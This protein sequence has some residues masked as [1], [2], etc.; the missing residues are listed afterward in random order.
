MKMKTK[1]SALV[2]A[3]SIFGTGTVAVRAEENK[4]LASVS[5][6]VSIDNGG[7]TL[8]SNDKTP[9]IYIDSS[10]DYAVARAAGDL[11]TDIEKVTGVKPSFTE[12]ET[13]KKYGIYYKNGTMKMRPPEYNAT[14]T[15]IA[16]EYNENG[17]VINTSIS[18]NTDENGEFIFDKTIYVEDN[19][20]IKGF[21]WDSLDSM[22]PLIDK[23]VGLMELDVQ[24]ADADIIIGTVGQSEAIDKLVSDGKIDV[25]DIEGKWECFKIQVV[26]DTLVIAG[27]DRRGTIYGIYDLSEKIG[28][29]P[30]YYWA[31]TPIGQADAL[32]INL[33]NPYT[34]GEPSVKYRGIFMNDEMSFKNRAVE[35]G[36]TDLS[37]TYTHIYELILR[38]KANYMWPAMQEVTPSFHANPVN[39]ENADKYG[40]VMGA[41]HCEMLMRNNVKELKPFE[42]K[43]TSEN[44]E[45]TLYIKDFGGLSGEQ[46]YVYT[47]TNPDTGE[48]VY[49]KE[50][51]HDYW[52]ESL[53]TYGS[54]DNLYN[55]GMRGMHDEAWS[56]VG[57]STVEEKAALQEEIIT[58]QRGLIQEVLGKKAEE[59]PQMFIPYKEMQEVY[60]SGMNIPDDVT[61]MWTDDNYGYIRQLPTDENRSRE[62]GAGIYYHISYHGNPN[63]YLWLCTTPLAQIREE[64]VKAYDNNAKQVWVANVGD[65]KPGERQIEYFLDLA[66]NINTKDTDLQEYTAEK[67]KR[68]YQMTDEQAAEYGRMAVEFDKLSFARKPEIFANNLFNLT[69]YGD[70]GEKYVKKYEELTARCESLY[71]ETNESAKPSLFEMLL[72][73]LRSCYNT[74]KKYIYAD[75]SNSYFAAGRGASVNKYAEESDNSYS[76]IVRD[77]DTYNSMFNKKWNKIMDPFQNYWS[78]RFG[79]MNAIVSKTISTS[80]AECGN[81]T[82]MNWSHENLD[83]SAYSTDTRFVDIYNTGIGS[84]EY[85]ITADKDWV[86]INKTGGTVY[87]DDRVWIGVDKDKAQSGI[88]TATLAVERISDGEVVERDSAVITFN[89]N[90]SVL[91]EKTYAEAD[92]YVSI[93]AEHFSNAVGI[94]DYKWQIEK[95]F[96]RSG[97]SLKAYPNHG[98]CS[99]NPTMDNTA[100]VEYNAYFEN[101]GN[102]D[103]DIYRIPTLNERGSVR[104]AI[105]VDDN[106]PT[107]VTG[108]NKY[109]GASGNDNWSK[110]VMNNNETLTTKLDIT[111]AGEHK[112]RL[113]MIDTGVIIDKIV[114]TTGEKQATYFGAEESYNTTYN[115]EIQILP[116]PNET[117]PDEEQLMSMNLYSQ[118]F[119]ADISSNSTIALAGGTSYN[120]TSG[121]VKMNG[122]TGGTMTVNTGT[123][124][125]QGQSVSVSSD[126]AYGKISGKYMTYK[127]LDSNGTELINSNISAYNASGS[128]HS[129]KVG[130]AEQL[131]GIYPSVIRNANSALSAGYTRYT[132]VINSEH[133]TITLKIINLGTKEF[134]QYSSPIPDGVT[135]VASMVFSTDYNDSERSCY[136]DNVSVD[137]M[138]KPQ[139]TTTVKA[140]DKNGTE[141]TNA[142]ITITDA[143]YG[144]IINPQQDG[145]YLL[146]DGE[147]NYSVTANGETKENSFNITADNSNVEV[148]FDIEYENRLNVSTVV[149]DYT[150]GEDTELFTW[151]G[152][153]ENKPV[154]ASINLSGSTSYDTDKGRIK[155]LNGG[156]TMELENSFTTDITNKTVV[157]FDMYF[158]KENKKYTYYT[159]TGDNGEIVKFTINEY[160]N[161][162]DNTKLNIGGKSDISSKDI[163]NTL[164][165]SQ[166]KANDNGVRHFKNVIDFATGE[167]EVYMTNGAVIT[168]FSG[169]TTAQSLEGMSFTTDHMVSDRYGYVDNIIVKTEVQEVKN[170]VF[171][172][173]LNGENTDDVAITVTNT[174]TGAETTYIYGGILLRNGNYRYTAETPDGDKVVGNFTVGELE[175]VLSGKTVYAFGDSIVYGHTDP[176]NSFINMI[177]DDNNMTLGKYAINGASIIGTGSYSIYKQ[178]VSAPSKVPDIIVFDGYTNDANNSNITNLYGTV[179]GADAESYDTS[180]F[181]GSFENT[182]KTMKE[183]WGNDVPIV[184]VT[185]HK[186]EAR[187][188]EIQTRLV[189][190]SRDICDKW[191]IDVADVFNDSALDTRIDGQT[192][193]YIID[194]VGT[195]PNMDACREFYVSIIQKKMM[196]CLE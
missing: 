62:G 61:L 13:N 56:P 124:F 152:T 184:F 87:T 29:S 83:F 93:E 156:V 172:S 17:E 4:M 181:S 78:P 36:D 107:I 58:M 25:S 2:T 35:K 10:E 125:M 175:N 177:T 110:G 82:R 69:G 157:E 137:V 192:E 180:T 80:T 127:L 11:Q 43:W 95:D 148:Q 76:V 165:I 138:S 96:G 195:H 40:I 174:D 91:G 194:G 183:K 88:N 28:V 99:E 30:W 187:D 160:N 54:Y 142:D 23:P 3:V 86:K 5:G 133:N 7:Y 131:T 46:A 168:K 102:F 129:I 128:T 108:T 48:K 31:D 151:D 6:Y 22:K 21:V 90:S 144:T 101:T 97:D 73:P 173:M 51:L 8:V 189:E 33:N 146:C 134:V 132:T 45:K 190:L 145:T 166:N 153:E 60:D 9:S 139:N 115:N 185:I 39:A 89:N 103:V 158:A 182:I 18:E 191:G 26:D 113:Y 1:V 92:G 100:Y 81:Y 12:T 52:K 34:E 178:V 112:I 72:Y 59:V 42:E 65:I 55:I 16:V 193:K 79:S 179:Q 75:K 41:S 130:G 150:T 32:Y 118:D 104:F 14:G 140:V 77:T 126:I 74:A 15:A 162:S 84:F 105:G 155:L 63:S 57:V 163:L 122:S 71:D 44:P 116:T 119:S 20:E 196:E 135:D 70:E 38:L 120:S 24:F 169:A 109:S 149:E 53:E 117:N 50:F 147:Y 154:E 123:G 47:D 164:L 106:A 19:K 176:D 64:M 66:R 94:N 136:V 141:I 121:A 85:R 143:V 49:N 186:S 170:V 98:I 37:D 167:V 114:V 27:S 188:W 111:T 161:S 67:A 171:T 68:D 159:I